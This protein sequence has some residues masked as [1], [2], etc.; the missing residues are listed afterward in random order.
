MNAKFTMRTAIGCSILM[1]VCQSAAL[2]GGKGGG[3]NSGGSSRISNFNAVRINTF[4]TPVQNQKF[5]TLNSNSLR[6]NTNTLQ[7]TPKVLHVTPNVNNGLPTGTVKV[8]K[9]P[10]KIKLPLNGWIFQPPLGGNKNPSG[11][12]S[13]PHQPQILAK[14][15]DRMTLK[16]GQSYT[17]V[18]DKFGEQS[19]DL[20]LAI[21]GLTLPMRVEQWDAQ[22]ITFTVPFLGLEKPTNGMF[23]VW[24]ADHKLVMA[25]PVIVV[26]AQ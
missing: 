6:F 4:Q 22:Q 1:V 14:A 20:S 19:G 26:A 17:I 21:G 12:G 25:V 23:Q 11:G 10:G 9:V 2:A 13:K 7:V 3:G 15:A 16:L 8:I 18:N 24:V 5:Q